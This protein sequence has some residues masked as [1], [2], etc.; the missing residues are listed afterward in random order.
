MMKVDHPLSTKSVSN[1]SVK[2][3]HCL[4]N[5][6]YDQVG[7]NVDFMDCIYVCN[8]YQFLPV[9]PT[10][11]YFYFSLLWSALEDQ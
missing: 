4:I 10:Y 6:C 2:E 3:H 9:L 11:L 7:Q 1:Q 5:F 8:L